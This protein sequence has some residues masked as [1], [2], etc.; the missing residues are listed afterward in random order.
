MAVIES[1]A[2]EVPVLATSVGGATEVVTPPENGL[3]LPPRQPDAWAEALEELVE[4][5]ARRESMGRA[6]RSR[7]AEFLTVES[8]VERVLSG[9]REVLSPDGRA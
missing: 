9:Y 2:M 8:Y 3:L 7:V 4:H 5:P 6:A 1:M